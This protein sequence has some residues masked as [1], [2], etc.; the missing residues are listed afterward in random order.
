MPLLE[1]DPGNTG[2]VLFGVIMVIMAQ[3]IHII[4]TTR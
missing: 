3:M 2:Y 4:R 1:M